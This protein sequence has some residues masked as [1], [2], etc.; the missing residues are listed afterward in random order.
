MSAQ[1]TDIDEYSQVH[2]NVFGTPLRVLDHGEGCYV[3]DVDGNKYLDFLA[4]IA[5]NSIGYA[6]PR[7]VE[8]V[9]KQAAQIAHTSN[10]FATE[11]Q[12]HLAEKLI[13]HA[14]APEG[15][16]VYFCNSGAEANEAALKLARLH[17]RTLQGALPSIGGKPARILALTNGFHGRTLGALSATW[18]PD[19]RKPFDPLVPAIEFVE[20]GSIDAMRAAFAQTGI[21]KY[22]KGPVAAV[23]MEL[24]QGE[25]GVLPFDADY[26]AAVRKMCTDNGAFMMIDEVQTG[27]G[28]TGSWFAFQRDDLT[29]GIVPD[30]VSFAKG[31][32]GG[33]P[34][35]GLIVFGAKNSALFTPGSH[36]S[37]FA[38]N[39]LGASAAL[40]TLGVMEEENLVTNAE[41]RGNQLRSALES[42]GNEIFGMVRGRGLLNA[43]TLKRPCAHAIVDW[44]LN[45][46]LIVNAVRPD[47]IRLAPPLVVS[48]SEI[49]EAVSIL[50]Q[51]PADLPLD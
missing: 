13:E 29:H 6:H 34:M 12:I 32:A 23:I 38:G 7:W 11:P 35:G 4:G 19:I 2:L 45:H 46:G 24:I 21:G 48:E 30:A 16:K 10:Y 31:V 9:S 8:A 51:V 14:G 33:F 5:V 49:K 42:C 26:V 43:V 22:G 40:A 27:V 18:K 25:A 3:W 20:A 47:V 39:P 41:T 1:T 36:G 50:A 15:S 17:G 28:R 37:T 44:A